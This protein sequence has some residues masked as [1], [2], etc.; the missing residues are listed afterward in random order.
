MFELRA[1]NGNLVRALALCGIV[2]PVVF[3]IIVTIGG[4]IYEGYSHAT[5]AISELGGVEAEHGLLQEIN[6]FIV[7]SMFILFALG[8]HLGIGNGRG[9]IVGPALVAVFGL[10]SGIGNG[11]FPCD[12]GC[13]AE[14]WQGFMHNGTG[15]FEFLA[16][17][18]GIF[19]ISRRIKSDPEWNSFYQFS[20]IFCAACFGALV[21]WIAVGRIADVESLTGV[22]QRLYVAVWFTWAMGMALK[23]LSVWRESPFGTRTGQGLLSSKA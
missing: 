16:G 23:M 3:A 18:T 7:G 22:L 19:F 13:D 6:F 1:N 11:I 20:R 12:S 10:S 2:G 15:P 4:S 5:Q 17:I 8:L 9:S 14:T 21:L